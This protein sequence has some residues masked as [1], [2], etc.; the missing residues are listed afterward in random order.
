MIF[1]KH[2]NGFPKSLRCSEENTSIFLLTNICLPINRLKPEKR[3]NAPDADLSV[4]NVNKSKYRH[5][6]I[7][8]NRFGGTFH[9]ILML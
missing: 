6:N 3:K 7:R 9:Q 1:Q 8:K 2:G 5:V 4:R